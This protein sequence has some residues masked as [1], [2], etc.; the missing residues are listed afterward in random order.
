[1]SHAKSEMALNT[2]VCQHAARL[3]KNVL[4]ALYK[5]ALVKFN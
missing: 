2:Y 1:M 4:E 5:C 3:Y